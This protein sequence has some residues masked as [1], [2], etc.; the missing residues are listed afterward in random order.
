MIF[1]NISESGQR[2]DESNVSVALEAS[3]TE[4]VL[5]AETAVPPQPEV[6]SSFPPMRSYSSS[7]SEGEDPYFDAEEILENLVV[8]AED[9]D[10]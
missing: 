2:R 6:P 9:I 8:S 10:R 4:L 7:E 5:S 3:E 1:S